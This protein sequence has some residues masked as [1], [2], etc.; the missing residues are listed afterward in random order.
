[1]AEK[2]MLELVFEIGMAAWGT[3][4]EQGRAH[5]PRSVSCCMTR[6]CAEN[7]AGSAG[8]KSAHV[9]NKQKLAA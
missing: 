4:I 7:P 2:I 9:K 1:M 5:A 8:E 3:S 6:G